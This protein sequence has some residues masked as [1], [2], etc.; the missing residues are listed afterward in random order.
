MLIRLPAWTKDDG[1]I[2]RVAAEQKK[3]AVRLLVEPDRAGLSAL[4]DLVQRGRLTPHIEHIFPLEQTS[5]AHRLID[6][7]RTTGKIILQLAS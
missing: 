3:I 2:R 5:S 6:T 7:G 4:S 1:H